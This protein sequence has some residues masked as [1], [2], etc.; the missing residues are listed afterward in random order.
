[1]KKIIYLTVFISTIFGCLGF[2]NHTSAKSIFSEGYARIVKGDVNAARRAAVEAALFYAALEDKTQINGNTIFEDGILKRD[3]FIISSGKKIISVKIL[4]EKITDQTIEVKIEVKFSNKETKNCK[5]R[6]VE[7]VFAKPKYEQINTIPNFLLGSKEFIFNQIIDKFS[8]NMS[9]SK[10]DRSD[11]SV[12]DIFNNNNPYRYKF[13]T[14]YKEQNFQQKFIID[15]V[16]SA[17]KNTSLFFSSL[18][19]DIKLVAI[20][21]L[22]REKIQTAVH[23]INLPLEIDIPIDLFDRALPLDKV[24]TSGSNNILMSIRRQISDLDIF[25]FTSISCRPLEGKASVKNNILTVDIGNSQGL[26]NTYLGYLKISGKN[27][28]F[29][30]TEVSEYAAVLIPLDESVPSS[31]YDGKIIQFRESS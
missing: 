25:N 31:N 1:M 20:N 3:K 30:V 17:N 29:E 10:V 2:Y 5:K 22:N 11:Y 9:I 15:T 18:Y 28:V 27:Y 24:F 13:I 7:I 23:R 19:F 16:I 12:S 8:Q 26:R 21:A 4:N 14:Q 6:N